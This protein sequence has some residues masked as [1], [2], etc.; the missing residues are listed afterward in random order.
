M[1]KKIVYIAH[2]LG[3]GVEREPNRQRASVWVAWAA[4]QG[5][6]PCASWIILAGQF[7]ESYRDMGMAI[8]KA[9]V[10]RSDEVWLCGTH[11]SPGMLEE[12][13]HAEDHGIL[14]IDKTGVLLPSFAGTGHRV[15]HQGKYRVL[16]VA[17]S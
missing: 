17:V 1:K 11:I 16:K 13:Y 4:L 8:D 5:V 7:D 14:V 10:E 3:S 15:E 12:K 9:L 6:A 2:P